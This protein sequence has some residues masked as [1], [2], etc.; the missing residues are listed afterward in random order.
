MITCSFQQQKCNRDVNDTEIQLNVAGGIFGF[1]RNQGGQLEVMDEIGGIE[2]RQMVQINER[3]S[4]RQFLAVPR[5][6]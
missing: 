3:S 4:R 2:Y 5:Q 1:G 6:L